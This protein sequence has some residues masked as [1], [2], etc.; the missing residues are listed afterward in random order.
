[1]CQALCLFFVLPYMFSCKEP[2]PF[3]RFKNWVFGRINHLSLITGAIDTSVRIWIQWHSRVCVLFSHNHSL[4]TSLRGLLP[5]GRD[6]KFPQYNEGVHWV[7]PPPDLSNSIHIVTPFCPATTY[8]FS[9]TKDPGGSRFP[10][11]LHFLYH[12]WHTSA[13]KKK[14]PLWA[15]PM[16]HSYLKIWCLT[17]SK[18]SG[19]KCC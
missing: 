3:C 4:N 11:S 6:L 5:K 7:H 18:C 13:T 16:A 17:Q 14:I 15:G 1:M 2:P 19:R 8:M 12:R 10:L 9:L